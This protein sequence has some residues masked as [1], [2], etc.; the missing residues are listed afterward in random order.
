[1]PHIGAYVFSQF[2]ISCALN[3]QKFIGSAY[4]YIFALPEEKLMYQK[5]NDNEK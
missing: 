4:L 2:I 3:A 5:L 1:M